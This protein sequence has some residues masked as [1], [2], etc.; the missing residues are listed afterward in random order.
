MAFECLLVFGEKNEKLVGRWLV[1]HACHVGHHQ[2]LLFGNHLAYEKLET[3]HQK[4]NC[5]CDSLH[6]LSFQKLGFCTICFFYLTWILLKFAFCLLLD[7]AKI[8]F[9]CPL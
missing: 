4:S 6:V 7:F 3:R 2:C 8:W 1:M 5:I 9:L